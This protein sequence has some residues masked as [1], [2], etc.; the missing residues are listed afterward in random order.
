MLYGVSDGLLKKLQA[1]QNA[2]AR[3]VT[4]ARKFDHIT[5]VLRDLHWL[6]VRQRIKYKLA[7]TA[8]K[9]LHGLAPTYLVDDCHAISAIA[10]KRH[11]RSA[12]T[13]TLFVPRTTTTLGMRSFAVAGPRIW[14]S[15]P[16]A[17]RTATLSPLT[18]AR[19]LKSHL[20]D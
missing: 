5:P 10:G 14:N 12:D 6:P 2:A 18:F 8:Y 4:G 19:H 20:F 11:L 7:M 17:L 16:A 13:G 1:V 3:V 9:C 15:L